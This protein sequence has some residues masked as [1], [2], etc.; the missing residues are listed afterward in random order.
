GGEVLYIAEGVAQAA[1]G[2]IR[3]PVRGAQADGARGLVRGL[4]SGVFG[5]VLKPAK[6]VAKAGVNAY[7][8][9]R[10][11]VSKAGRVVVGGS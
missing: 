4:G 2:L 8:G 5:V 6:G 1:M 9:V 10:M 7:T 11:G 3:D